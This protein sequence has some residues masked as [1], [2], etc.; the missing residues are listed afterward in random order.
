MQSIGSTHSEVYG[1]LS[2]HHHLHFLNLGIS[3]PEAACWLW[4]GCLF[5]WCFSSSGNSHSG[6]CSVFTGCLVSL[7][8]ASLLIIRLRGFPS[9]LIF[10]HLFHVVHVSIFKLRPGISGS[11]LTKLCFVLFFFPLSSFPQWSLWNH[12]C[13]FCSFIPLVI[14]ENLSIQFKNFLFVYWKLSSHS[15]SSYS[16]EVSSSMSFFFVSETFS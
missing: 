15:R 5:P 11:F 2:Y 10:S 4:A 6:L 8:S 7:L 14:A 13:L 12:L 3:Q 16:Q 1:F 9:R